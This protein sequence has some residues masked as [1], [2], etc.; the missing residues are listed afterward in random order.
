MKTCIILVMQSAVGIV[1]GVKQGDGHVAI[2]QVRSETD[3]FPRACQVTAHGKLTEDEMKMPDLKGFACALIRETREE[4]GPSI[5]E[6]VQQMIEASNTSLRLL[7]RL[8]QPEKGKLVVT[9]GLQT[10][11]TE[12]EFFE[13]VVSEPGVSFRVCRDA[14][15]ILPLTKEHKTSGALANETRM[16]TD[17]QQAIAEFLRL[18]PR[19]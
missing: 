15:I 10:N 1:L 16:F 14:G 18:P 13:K 19:P 9:F 8:E 17:E 7:Q 11:I 6:V 3:S 12:Q 2:L 4:L 5:A